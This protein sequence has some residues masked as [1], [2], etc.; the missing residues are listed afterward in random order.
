MLGQQR[1]HRLEEGRHLPHKDDALARLLDG[2]KRLSE[3]SAEAFLTEAL[4]VGLPISRDDYH[5]GLR[6]P[7]KL[8]QESLVNAV[9]AP[10]SGPHRATRGRC[11]LPHFETGHCL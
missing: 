6:V 7:E 1:R 11:V 4:V 8:G 9:A 5:V 2:I 3:T 10:L